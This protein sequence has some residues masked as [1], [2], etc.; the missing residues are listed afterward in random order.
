[1]GGR[2]WATIAAPVAASGN[3]AASNC[4]NHV[5]PAESCTMKPGLTLSGLAQVTVIGQAPALD[6]RLVRVDFTWLDDPVRRAAL[7]GDEP[8][9]FECV[10]DPFLDR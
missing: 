3:R 4:T 6:S 10:L 1:M 8:R 9:F 5:T 7:I 2:D